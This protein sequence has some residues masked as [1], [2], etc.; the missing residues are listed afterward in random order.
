VLN[1]LR[2]VEEPVLAVIDYAETRSDL[3]DLLAPVGRDDSAGP[4]RVLLLA[5]GAGDW[6]QQLKHASAE[7][8]WLMAGAAEQTLG[9]QDPSQ[10]DRA[11]AFVEAMQAFTSVQRMERRFVPVPDLGGPQFDNMLWIHMAALDAIGM[12]EDPESGAATSKPVLTAILERESRYWQ[13]SARKHG[14]GT[15]DRVLE[16]WSSSQRY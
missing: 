1:R 4:R 12:P 5:R 7:L 2:E 11:A 8:E 13:R 16:R 10:S 9:P 14:L 15:A 6:W 3:T